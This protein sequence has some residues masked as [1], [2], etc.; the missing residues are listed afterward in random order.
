MSAFGN[1]DSAVS[2]FGRVFMVDELNAEAKV[3]H[4]H[5]SPSTTSLAPD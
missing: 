3:C 1:N 5:P 4:H 2:A